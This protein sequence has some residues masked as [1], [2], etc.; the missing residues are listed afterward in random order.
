MLLS[1]SSKKGAPKGALELLSLT[2][3]YP[4]GFT[5]T[6]IVSSSKG[7]ED[8]VS[9]LYFSL[10]FIYL[11][12]FKLS[13]KNRRSPILFTPV[14]RY[15]GLKFKTVSLITWYVRVPTLTLYETIKL[16]VPEAEDALFES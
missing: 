16:T 7:L 6:L 5:I 10:T 14:I 4:G 9:V 12:G 15:K 13:V 11:G 2:R 1:N 3:L 8:V